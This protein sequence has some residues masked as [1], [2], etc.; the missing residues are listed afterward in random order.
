MEVY[1]FH[2]LLRHAQLVLIEH[3][4]QEV[5][6]ALLTLGLELL[7]GPLLLMQQYLALIY[8]AV[9]LILLPTVMHLLGLIFVKLERDLT[10]LIYLFLKIY[11]DI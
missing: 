4:I 11:I 9:Y 6:S 8:L 3:S 1:L 2:S 10:K 7:H 5:V